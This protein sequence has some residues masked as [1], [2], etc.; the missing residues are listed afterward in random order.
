MNFTTFSF[1]LLTICHH[2]VPCLSFY[3]SSFPAAAVAD[4]A[5]GCGGAVCRWASFPLVFPQCQW[6]AGS[7]YTIPRHLPGTA[8]CVQIVQCGSYQNT[9]CAS[10]KAPDG[11]LIVAI[12]WAMGGN[13]Q[14]SIRGLW[15]GVTCSAGDQPVSRWSTS[16][17]CP[18]TNSGS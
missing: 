16:Q 8:F 4:A 5:A 7:A 9:F 12:H 6:S 10:S 13:I 3:S 1:F 17:C 11:R 14:A 18:L 2:I 15:W